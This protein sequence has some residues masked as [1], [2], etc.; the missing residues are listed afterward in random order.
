MLLY[1]FL[2]ICFVFTLI[3]V[4]NNKKGEYLKHFLQSLILYSILFCIIKISFYLNHFTNGSFD[5][6]T[7]S[8]FVIIS[9]VSYLIYQFREVR[10][11]WDRL[12]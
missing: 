11:R 5:S 2:F 3:A 6:G 1:I 8:L 10:T 12:D 4:F 9:L 7:I